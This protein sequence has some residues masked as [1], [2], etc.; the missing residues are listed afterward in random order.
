LDSNHFEAIENL[1]F[2]RK[3]G[4]IVQLPNGETVI[5]KQGKL[6]FEKAKVVKIE[7]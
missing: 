2:S 3:S 5:K 7:P 4:K 1:I 6:L